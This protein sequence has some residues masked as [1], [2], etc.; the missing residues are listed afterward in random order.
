[1]RTILV[2]GLSLAA[3][4]EYVV[5]DAGGSTT[6]GSSTTTEGSSSSTGTGTGTGTGTDTGADTDEP[7]PCENLDQMPCESAPQCIW[8]PQSQTCMRTE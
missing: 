8:D 4:C 6:G 5:V 7:Q 2:L 3:G 1:M